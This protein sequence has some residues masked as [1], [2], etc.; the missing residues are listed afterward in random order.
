[1]DV[2]A[3]EQTSL[4]LASPTP[5]R[6]QES[7]ASPDGSR[8][9]SISNDLQDR[10]DGRDHFQPDSV[11]SRS[12]RDGEHPTSLASLAAFPE[13]PTHF[14]LPNTTGT[15]TGHQANSSMSGPVSGQSTPG[16]A[17]PSES[18]TMRSVR[19]GP[20]TPSVSFAAMPRV[21]ESPQHEADPRT[22]I[23]EPDVLAAGY[24]FPT[25]EKVEA[26]ESK[27]AVSPPVHGL[28]EELAPP[29]KHM[30][31]AAAPQYS[32]P[33]TSDSAE[34]PTEPEAD[35]TS[36]APLSPS[37]TGTATLSASGHSSATALALRR[38]DYLGER[39]FGVDRLGNNAS[40]SL[41]AIKNKAVYRSDSS[42]SNGSV[43]ASM[44]GRYTHTVGP[45]H[46]FAV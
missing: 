42:N 16:L 10:G 11:A 33:S 29:P 12:P 7:S 31:S 35:P 20:R 25:A 39:E 40:K 30:E 2:P 45:L 19:S 43:V 9:P 5:L 46:S 44:R 3:H 37:D 6:P 41:D 18:S 26:K 17:S 4:G 23:T 22:P 28:G 27:Q 14:P 1:M 8:R 38:G 32:E 36:I 13:P 24:P 34:R 21:V 15:P